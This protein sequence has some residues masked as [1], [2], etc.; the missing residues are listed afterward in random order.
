M[1]GCM[2]Q[3]MPSHSQNAER[4]IDNYIR[5]NNATLDVMELI[6]R[7]F[8]GN[9]VNFSEWNDVVEHYRSMDWDGESFER[10]LNISRDTI[11]SNVKQITE[12]YLNITEPEDLSR[13]FV[14]EQLDANS[15]NP[16]SSADER[17]GFIYRTIDDGVFACSYFYTTISIQVTRE[18]SIEEFPDRKSINLRIDPNRRLIIIESTYPAY[19]RKVEGIINNDTDM[20]TETCGDLTAFPDQADERIGNFI[21]KFR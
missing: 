19:V 11:E 17:V 12:S 18:P 2:L 9:E 20:N 8:T 7:Q 5:A 15:V 10:F 4:I 21:K 1:V 14:R 6:H 16:E 3:V 13:E